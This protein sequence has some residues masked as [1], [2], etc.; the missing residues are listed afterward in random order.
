MVQ[1]DST[2]TFSPDVEAVTLRDPVLDEL[3]LNLTNESRRCLAHH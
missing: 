2:W 1:I 3:S